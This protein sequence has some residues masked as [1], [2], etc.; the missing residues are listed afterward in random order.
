MSAAC[1]VSDNSGTCA[2]SPDACVALLPLMSTV[3]VSSQDADRAHGLPPSKTLP[4]ASAI[5]P[6]SY[7][8]SGGSEDASDIDSERELFAYCRGCFCSGFGF[9]SASACCVCLLLC[10]VPTMVRWWCTNDVSS[11][12]F[13]SREH[14]AA[15]KQDQ[16]QAAGGAC[17]K[18]CLG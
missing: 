13:A 4:A 14:A 16:P 10:L 7:A 1:Q 18:R 15:P 8:S 17:I 9:A 3:A 11:R 12:T 6:A 2:A 5:L